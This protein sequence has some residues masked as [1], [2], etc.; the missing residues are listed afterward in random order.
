MDIIENMKQKLKKEYA[1]L[2]EKVEKLDAFLDEEHDALLC[3]QELLVAQFNSMCTYMVI[4][5]M[6]ID[7]LEADELD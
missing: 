3:P 6:R 1:E 5:Q 7:Y 4:L 2:K